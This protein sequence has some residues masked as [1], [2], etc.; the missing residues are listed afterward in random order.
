MLPKQYWDIK[1]DLIWP[2]RLVGE[3]DPV[4]RTLAQSKIKGA[5]V[6]AVVPAVSNAQDIQ[7]RS[8]GPV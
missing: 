7:D 4:E 2:T 3:T 5:E 1:P 6:D 8:G